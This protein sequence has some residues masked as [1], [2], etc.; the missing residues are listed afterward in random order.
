MP[1]TNIS[2]VCKRF[3]AVQWHDSKLLSCALIVEDHT[4]RLEL[5]VDVLNTPGVNEYE[6]TLIVFQGCRSFVCDLDLLGIEVCG[7]DIAGAVC[8]SDS[9]LKQQLLST[10]PTRFMGIPE[11]R[12]PL[13][14][15]YHF[16]ISMISPGGELNIL[17]EDFELRTVKEE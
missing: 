12:S 2:D 10:L 17:A 6:E 1:D 4:Y 8:Y 16:G 3:E 11:L 14:E 5:R 7:G 13:D 9:P 15:T